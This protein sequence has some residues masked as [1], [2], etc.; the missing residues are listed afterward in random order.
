M[1]RKYWRAWDLTWA[2][3][4]HLKEHSDRYFFATNISNEF[5]I[6]WIEADLA[7]RL[8]AAKGIVCRRNDGR[9]IFNGYWKESKSQ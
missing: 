9:Y 1:K 7:L 5:E 6:P 3:V 8:A 2:V 4:R